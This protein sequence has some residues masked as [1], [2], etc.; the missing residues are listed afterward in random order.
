MLCYY[1][2][3]ICYANL[4]ELAQLPHNRSCV[5]V[6]AVANCGERRGGCR[7][8][9]RSNATNKGI[10]ENQV[11]GIWAYW[12]N[13]R[14]W[15]LRDSESGSRTQLQKF[16]VFLY[17]TCIFPFVSLSV[18]AWFNVGRTFG[19]PHVGTVAILA[20]GTDWAVAVMQAFFVRGSIPAARRSCLASLVDPH[21]SFD[22]ESVAKYVCNLS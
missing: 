17:H 3:L 12:V 13:C 15:N 22:V 14:I 20:Q 19:S 9:K 10:L 11:V 6:G 8:R 7:L 18:L 1:A 16:G 5:S 2:L 4:R 21:L